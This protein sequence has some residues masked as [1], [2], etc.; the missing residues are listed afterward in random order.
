MNEITLTLSGLTQPQAQS[1]LSHY[2]NV[3]GDKP[4]TAAT[5]ETKVTRAA[6][7][8]TTKKAK[9]KPPVEEDDALLEDEE[10]AEEVAEAS[11]D[12]EM[13]EED[14]A[15]ELDED[16]AEE[17]AE[18]GEEI[19]KATVQ[20]AFKKFMKNFKVKGKVDV[21]AG[22]KAAIK[23]LKTV[24]AKSVDDIKAKDYS[25]VMELLEG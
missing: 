10:T 24:K 13:V 4:V 25:K 3:K 2:A 23:I 16:L 20:A 22:R 5:R 7:T 11:D 6:E 8:K 12:E 18:E 21:A 19:S 17:E 1:V 9:S 14:E 15:E